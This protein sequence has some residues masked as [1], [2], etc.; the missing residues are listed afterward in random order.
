MDVRTVWTPDRYA[1]HRIPGMA[2]TARGTLL[3]CCEAR[4]TFSDWARIDLLLCR[5]EDGGRIGEPL[6]LAS[7]DAEHPTVNNPVLIPA[8]D[9]R[10]FLLYCR[11]YSVDGGNV[12]LRVSEDDG[13]TWSAPRDLMAATRPAE[14]A[15]FAF[16][17]GHGIETPDGVLLS[18]VWFVPAGAHPDPR[19]HHPAR[20]SVFL[21]K[22]GGE[23]WSLGPVLAETPDCPDPNETAAAVTSGGGVYL[24]ARLTGAGYRAVSYAARGTDTFTPFSPARDLPD[25]TCMGSAAS[26]EY[27]GRHVLLFVNCASTD[28][29]H[30]LVCRASDDDGRTWPH[31]LTV[32][33]GDAGYADLAVKDGNVF[34]LYEQ[35]WGEV[36]RLAHFGLDELIADGS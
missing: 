8:R 34:V 35:R 6:L 7:G 13:L 4:D 32:E 19:S 36:V 5:S 26:A 23:T 10:V 1:A 30:S 33:P 2:V 31:A 16:G 20:V 14:H 29:R 17:P 3:L 28:G 24:N 18:P 9:G 21:S 25:P 27:R 11:D 15:A 12:F 22:D